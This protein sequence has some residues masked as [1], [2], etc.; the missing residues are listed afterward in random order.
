M[1]PPNRC[2]ASL[3]VWM[4]PDAVSVCSGSAFGFFVVMLKSPIMIWFG[5]FG[6]LCMMVTGTVMFGVWFGFA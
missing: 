5:L 6:M 4:Y 2:V 3:I 1:V